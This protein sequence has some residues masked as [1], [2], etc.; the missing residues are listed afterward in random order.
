MLA[1]LIKGFIC[2]CSSLFAIIMIS[3]FISNMHLPLCLLLSLRLVI[4]GTILSLEFLSLAVQ[5]IESQF[6]NS[7]CLNYH[8]PIWGFQDLNLLLVLQI[9]RDVKTLIVEMLQAAKTRVDYQPT[10]EEVCFQTFS[11][12][13]CLCGVQYTVANLVGYMLSEFG[14][15][16]KWGKKTTLRSEMLNVGQI[17]C[18]CNHH[19]HYL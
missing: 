10:S 11:H 2:N 14:V 8:F 15:I 12:F 9:C 6:S 4:K 17:L 3:N 18:P 5:K 1:I 7:K 16:G 13:S 19:H